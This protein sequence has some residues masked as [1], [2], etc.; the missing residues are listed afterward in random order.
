M[1]SSLAAIVA[2]VLAR[3]PEW[4]RHDLGG[5]DAAARTRAEEALAA[6]IA[7]ALPEQEGGPAAMPPGDEVSP[8]DSR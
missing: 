2:A 5:R 4:I 1:T 8:Q 7:S 3:A 6:M